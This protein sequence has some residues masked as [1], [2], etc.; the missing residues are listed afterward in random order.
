MLQY[1][2]KNSAG[3]TMKIET[4]AVMMNQSG[5]EKF[6]SMNIQSDAVFANQCESY[7]YIEEEINGFRARMI[8]T[9]TKG[10]GINRNFA[11]NLSEGDICIIADDDMVYNDGYTGIVLEAFER[12]PSADMLIFNIETLG[13]GAARRQNTKIKRVRNYNFMNYGAARV[14]FRRDALLRKNIWFS[15]L[16]G[17]GAIYS[18]GED[19]LFLRESLKKGLKIYTYPKSIGAVN[20]ETSTWF[21]GYNEKYFFDKG[22]LIEAVFPRLKHLFNGFYFP[23]KFMKK[24]QMSFG[25]IKKQMMRGSSAFKKGTGYNKAQ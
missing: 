2:D 18:S 15:H 8:S 25:G 13:E 23:I 11:L 20:Q 3:Y 4:L 17:G 16:F 5:L 14:A 9:A 19:T 1:A 6:N 7:G 21:T 24:T 10:V 22:A 12:L